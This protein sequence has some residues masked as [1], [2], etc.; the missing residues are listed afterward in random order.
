MF[1]ANIHWFATWIYLTI[2]Y[3][4]AVGLQTRIRND[5]KDTT[6]LSSRVRGRCVRHVARRVVLDLSSVERAVPT[7]MVGVHVGGI[8]RVR[9]L[10][11]DQRRGIHRVSVQD[12]ARGYAL[13]NHGVHVV[14]DAGLRE[15]LKK[16]KTFVFRFFLVS[17]VFRT[18]SCASN[19]YRT[20]AESSCVDVRRLLL[21][22]RALG[23]LSETKPPS[24]WTPRRTH[25][26]D[27]KPRRTPREPNNNP[28]CVYRYHG[29]Q[30]AIKVGN[31]NRNRG[32]VCLVVQKERHVVGLDVLVDEG[33]RFFVHRHIDHGVKRGFFAKILQVHAEHVQRVATLRTRKVRLLGVHA[34][35]MRRRANV[36]PQTLF[37]KPMTA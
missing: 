36:F 35:V 27:T 4:D 15:V 32:L 29:H 7:E 25:R 33:E 21:P 6:H 8:R 34:V 30:Q 3:N 10:Q 14:G 31:K 11:L 2:Q 16:T 18:R 12:G 23:F 1:N 24:P 26:E 9:H 22:R 19:I 37:V 13:G 20:L 17:D 5:S 28:P